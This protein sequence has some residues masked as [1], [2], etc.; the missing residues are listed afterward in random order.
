[1]KAQTGWAEA[2]RRLSPYL[3]PA[4]GIVAAGAALTSL[5]TT[6]LGSLDSRLEDP[7]VVSAVATA[8]AAGA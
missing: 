1:M 4:I 8:A 2:S 3:D 7:D 6:D 5:L